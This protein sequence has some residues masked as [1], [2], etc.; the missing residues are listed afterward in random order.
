[1]IGYVRANGVEC[2]GEIYPFS[3]FVDLH[4]KD[5]FL[6]HLSSGFGRVAVNDYIGHK[7]TFVLN[8]AKK[9]DAIGLIDDEGDVIN[10]R[11]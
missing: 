5:W 2:E 1:M 9:A 4:G 11:N 3:W 7:V 10:L 6:P 8:Y